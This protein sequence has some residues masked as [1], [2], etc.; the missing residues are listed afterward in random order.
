[1]T[2]LDLGRPLLGEMAKLNSSDSITN[3]VAT[4]I[5]M[6]GLKSR[7]LDDRQIEILRK[8][9]LLYLQDLYARHNKGLIDDE[10]L[11]VDL[12]VIDEVSHIL[13]LKHVSPQYETE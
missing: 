4:T 2:A 6:F 8:S 9:V 13:H 7:L 3:T 12:S 10:Q 5:Q 1:M 11:R